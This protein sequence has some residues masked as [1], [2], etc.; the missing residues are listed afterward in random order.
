MQDL[1]RELRCD[2]SLR[3]V[4]DTTTLPAP[5]SGVANVGRRMIECGATPLR[6]T[7]SITHYAPGEEMPSPPSAGGEELLVLQ[8]E[9]SDE[10][11]HYS[12][13]M[14][15]RN[16]ASVRR[17]TTS[18]CVLFE[19]V[20]H[21][22]EDDRAPLMID[23]RSSVWQP[24]MYEG[25]QNLLLAAVGTERTVLVRWAAG[26]QIP[27]HTHATVEETLVIEG[28]LQDEFGAY[29]AGTWFRVP[30]GS[31]HAPRSRHGALILIKVGHV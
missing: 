21:L 13:G 3:E 23:T 30:Q 20:G 19:K 31:T 8:G 15:L 28:E 10:K 22:G 1:T 16:V 26:T 12:A 14:Y 27:P 11:V 7:T 4:V 17:R 2:F 5:V 18:G 24:G 25:L 9:F 29:P 6:R